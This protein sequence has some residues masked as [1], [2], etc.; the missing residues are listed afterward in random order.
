M[1]EMEKKKDTKL[2]KDKNEKKRVRA[3]VLVWRGKIPSD[4]YLNLSVFLSVQ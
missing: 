1:R 3:L 2:K 4:G